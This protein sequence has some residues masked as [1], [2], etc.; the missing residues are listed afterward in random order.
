M[1]L[2]YYPSG[3]LKESAMFKDGVREGK[4][5]VYDESGNIVSEKLFSNGLEVNE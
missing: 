3:K 5:I 1:W 2:W 4:T